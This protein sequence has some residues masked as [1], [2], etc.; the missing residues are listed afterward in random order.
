MNE[1]QRKCIH[2]EL[3]DAD[4]DIIER[5]ESKH[6]KIRYTDLVRYALV[7]L[8]VQLAENDKHSMRFIK[9]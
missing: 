7:S 1:H 6:G 9:L 5:I 8:E 3:R 2:V 4:M